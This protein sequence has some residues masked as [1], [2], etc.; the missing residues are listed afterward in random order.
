MPAMKE[1]SIRE[2]RA[3]LGKLDELLEEEGEIVLTRRGRKVARLLPMHPKRALPSHR[4]L[5]ARMPLLGPSADLI[6]TDRD[7]RG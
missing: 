7:E 1:L 4:D 2:M 6:R 5:R 3:A